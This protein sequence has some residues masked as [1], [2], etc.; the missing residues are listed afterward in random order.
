M[1]DAGRWHEVLPCPLPDTIPKM[2]AAKE[3]NA[4]RDGES[5]TVAAKLSVP[6]R[7]ELMDLL[8][9]GWRVD[10]MS[11]CREEI[12]RRLGRGPGDGVAGVD[13]HA[14]R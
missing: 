11:R 12:C 14:P 7:A 13:L 1:Y 8:R 6:L 3:E 4:K 9:K 2:S 5:G 10:V